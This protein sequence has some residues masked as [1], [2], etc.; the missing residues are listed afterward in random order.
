MIVATF[1]YSTTIE[2]TSQIRL[3]LLPISAVIVLIGFYLRSKEPNQ[4]VGAGLANIVLMG[5]IIGIIAVFGE[6]IRLFDIQFLALSNEIRDSSKDVWEEINYNPA[7]TGE[8]FSFVDL[9]K[10]GDILQ[11]IYYALL[12]FVIYLAFLLQQIF[13]FFRDWILIIA[14]A[15][16]PIF[17]ATIMIRNFAHI[18][19]TFLATSFAVLLWP[20]GF[21]LADIGAYSIFE[22]FTPAHSGN[23]SWNSPAFLA[24]IA[25]SGGWIILS[26]IAIPGILA[27]LAKSGGDAGSAL[28]GGQGSGMMGAL[29]MANTATMLAS[30]GGGSDG[31]GIAGINSKLDT[32]MS[33]GGQGSES[34]SMSNNSSG[35]M[36]SQSIGG[37]GSAA[38]GGGGMGSGG[39]TPPNDGG[40]LSGGSTSNQNA[41]VAQAKNEA[42]TS[43]DPTG[44]KAANMIAL[45]SSITKPNNMV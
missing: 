20:V 30:R 3:L 35:S 45:D 15:L 12:R 6:I 16:S 38:P 18:G 19:T 1:D 21:A 2:Q 22:N 24:V 41:A 8:G 23:P 39:G 31:G 34:S 4:E 36:I 17:I 42:F 33:S 25:I 28:V 32:I 9:I 11:G 14:V 40:S 10:G 5:A 7:S 26:Y 43:A 29:M 13:E 44:D 37:G 27:T